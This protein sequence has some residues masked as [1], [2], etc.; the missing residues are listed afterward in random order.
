MS[1]QALENAAL[2]LKN[3]RCALA[4]TGAGISVE[5]GVPPFRGPG[6][7]WSK[8]DPDMFEKGYFKRHPEEVWPLLKEIFY[9]TLGRAR[10]NP[11]HTALAELEAVGK[12]AGIITQNIDS[13]HQAAGSGVVHEY[14]GS[15]RRMQCMHCREFFASETISL[16]KL[17]PLCPHC[18]GL[19][20]PDFVFFGEGIPTAVHIAA[21]ELAEQ[22]DVCLI[23]GTG[24]Q[25]MP[26]GRI[27]YIV[28]NRGGTIIEVNLHDTDY[29]YTTSDYFLQGKAGEMTPKLV[30][31][32][33]A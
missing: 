11:A 6:G 9:D 29:S 20:K 32:A 17:P 22:S 13:L 24:G 28:K 16:E 18:S 19:L 23:I 14:H 26:A 7:V 8:Y 12:L 10:P 30:R 25:V 27:P 5:S 1:N 3:A 4:F 21:V 2:A 15:T 33:L 31:L